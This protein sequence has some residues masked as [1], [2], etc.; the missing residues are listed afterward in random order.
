MAWEIS[1]IEVNHSGA[2]DMPGDLWGALLTCTGR[3][4]LVLFLKIRAQKTESWGSGG[5]SG[6]WNLIYGT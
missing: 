1:E 5:N 3:F 4:L 2:W 6:V